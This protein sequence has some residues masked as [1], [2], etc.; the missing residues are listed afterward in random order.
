MPKMTPIHRLQLAVDNAPMSPML[1]TELAAILRDLETETQIRVWEK[2][3]VS[4]LA[5]GYLTDNK[6]N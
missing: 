6:G 2:A 3:E 5:Q 1:R 4:R